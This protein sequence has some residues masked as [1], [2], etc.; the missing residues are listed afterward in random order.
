MGQ[1]RGAF[2]AARVTRESQLHGIRGRQE[3]HFGCGNPKRP[4]LAWWRIGVEDCC[5]RKHPSVHFEENACKEAAKTR[6]SPEA[7]QLIGRVGGANGGELVHKV[8]RQDVEDSAAQ[9][10]RLWT[11]AAE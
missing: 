8:F 10:G 1:H 5:L 6:F 3:V 4:L 9:D 7:L 2:L 11:L